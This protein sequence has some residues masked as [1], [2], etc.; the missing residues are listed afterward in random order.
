ME[1]F[2]KRKASTSD[3]SGKPLNNLRNDLPSMPREVDLNNLPSNPTE[4]KRILQYHPNQREEIRRHYLIK[5]PCQ[6]RGHDFPKRIIGN[7]ARRFNPVW[8]DQYGNWFEYSLKLDKVFCLC[9]Y[10]FRDQCGG[11]GGSDAFLTEGFSSW[12]KHIETGKFFDMI[13]SL[14]NV[15]CASCK[16]TYMV[17]ESQKEKV[18]EAIGSDETETSSGLNQE[19][20]L[21]RPRDTRWGSHYKTL[22]RL[23]DLFP[24]VIEVLEYVEDVCENPYNQRQANG[25]QI[26]FQS[27]DSVFYLHLMLHILGVTESLSQALQKKDQD[28]LNAVSLVKSTKRQLQQFRVDGFCRLLEKIY[29][30]CEKHEH[31]NS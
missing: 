13:A 4:R 26:Y 1:R 27:F 31:R 14:M 17:Q 21:G 20:S 6:P 28:I 11:Q 22:K 7:K 15:V 9:C 24:S 10:L 16:R 2:L 30:F 25:L 12:N 5:G 18:Q 29:S 8:F 3:N 19:L 23:V